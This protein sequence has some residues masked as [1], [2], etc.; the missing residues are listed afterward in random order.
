MNDKEICGID[1]VPVSD[2]IPKYFPSKEL[3]ILYPLRG[4]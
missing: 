1:A 2:E 3:I 4:E